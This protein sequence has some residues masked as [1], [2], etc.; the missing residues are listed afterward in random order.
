MHCSVGDFEKEMFI[1]FFFSPL[2]P[3]TTAAPWL[4]LC[5]NEA[6]PMS[7]RLHPSPPRVLRQHQR[8]LVSLSPRDNNVERRRARERSRSRDETQTRATPTRFPPPPPQVMKSSYD[9]KFDQ[10]MFGVMGCGATNV[11][12]L[13]MCQGVPQMFWQP[14]AT[15]I[16]TGGALGSRSP[17]LDIGIP[18]PFAPVENWKYLGQQEDGYY[19]HRWQYIS[20]IDDDIP[21]E[22][23]NHFEKT[24]HG[25]YIEDD[26][27]SF[28]D[29]WKG[30]R[31]FWFIRSVQWV[32]SGEL[33]GGSY[34]KYWS[35]DYYAKQ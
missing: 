2:F 11:H 32:P 9:P 4:K 34:R 27:A 14:A 24:N 26:W 30:K 21:F 5:S 29:Y 17:F 16:N 20:G 8:V 23:R 25:T 10:S 3:C 1:S 22:D 19:R 12:E 7:V 31:I 18:L 33:H 35:W 15:P 6:I 13:N 28:D